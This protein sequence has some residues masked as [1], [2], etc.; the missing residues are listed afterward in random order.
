MP[1]PEEAEENPVDEGDFTDIAIY[2]RKGGATKW[3]CCEFMVST[4]NEAQMGLAAF[5]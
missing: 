2:I 5:I 1:M 4:N 3:L